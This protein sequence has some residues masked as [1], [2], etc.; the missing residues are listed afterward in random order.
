M[1]AF[2]DD[3]GVISDGVMLLRQVID[4]LSIDIKKIG[5]CL[6]P[7]KSMI[8]T[9]CSDFDKEEPWTYEIAIVKD[10]NGK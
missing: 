8:I 3:T 2:A 9:N 6:N 10:E 7:L 4:G 5:I 1:L